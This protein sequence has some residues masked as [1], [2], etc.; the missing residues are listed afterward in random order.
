MDSKKWLEC[1][2]EAWNE[3]HRTGADLAS[4]LKQK[5]QLPSVQMAEVLVGAFDEVAT[6]VE[7]DVGEQNVLDIEDVAVAR[8]RT[9]MRGVL[10]A[11]LQ[12]RIDD[13]DSAEK[14]RLA[15]TA[16]RLPSHKGGQAEDGK[17]NS[18]K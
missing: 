11:K 15:A 12:K 5:L 13:L 4:A 16:E 1:V 18:E 6:Y 7:D 9:V 3:G 14:K 10:E 2:A 8:S 17:A